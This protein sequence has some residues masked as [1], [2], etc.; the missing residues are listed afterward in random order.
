MTDG[1]SKPWY[2]KMVSAIPTPLHLLHFSE[3]MH[4]YLGIA[5]YKLRGWM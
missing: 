1:I 4:E 5:Y 3:V 2:R